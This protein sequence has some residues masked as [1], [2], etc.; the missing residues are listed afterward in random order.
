MMIDGRG[1]GGGRHIRVDGPAKK[2]GGERRG[3]KRREKVGERAR[4]GE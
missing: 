3:G 4:E 2:A 1:G